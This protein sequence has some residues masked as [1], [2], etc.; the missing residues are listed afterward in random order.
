MSDGGGGGL[1]LLLDSCSLKGFSTGNFLAYVAGGLWMVAV[2]SW[3]SLDGCCYFL[4]VSPWLLLLPG[5]LSMVA[6]D[7]WCFL[8]GCC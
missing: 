6:V 7:S 8:G 3:C 1:A 5:A 2:D 4:V